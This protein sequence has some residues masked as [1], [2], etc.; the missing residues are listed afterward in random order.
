MQVKQMFVI[1]AFALAAGAVVAQE[2][3]GTSLARAQV[4]QSVFDARAEGTLTPAG[5]GVS[6]SY[7]G[8]GPSHASRAAI[9]NE[10]LQARAAGDLV[11]AGGGS[12]SHK[13]YSQMV[14]ARSTL[15]RDQVKGQVLEA[16]AESALIPAGQGEFVS[17]EAAI[18]TARQ[19]APAHEV[20]AARTAR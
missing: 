13:S 1:G 19:T 3:S 5:E 20:L 7:G 10:V 18:H 8:A 2:S 4:I 15:T 11:S 17:P 12:P 14:A 16:R 9:K 6:P